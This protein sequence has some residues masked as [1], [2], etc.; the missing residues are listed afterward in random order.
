MTLKLGF[1]VNPIAGLGGKKAWKGTDYI[2]E[3]WIFFE[4]GEHYSFGRVKTA[5]ESIPDS[6]PLLI[7]YCGDPM[8]EEIINLFPFE[9]TLIYQPAGERTSAEDTKDAC[10]AFLDAKVDLILFVGGDGTARDVASIIKDQ[11]PVL[12]IPSGVK[13]HSGCF[14][15]RPE[16]LGDILE[17]MYFGD[18]TFA[19]ENVMDINEDLFRENRVESRLFGYL[20]VP[21]KIGL[22]QGGKVSSAFTSIETYESMAEELKDEYDV[23]NGIVILGTGGTV[24]HVIKSL[25]IEKTLLGIDILEN[26]KIINKDVNEETLYNVVKDRD[27]RMILTPIGGQGF[28][29]G[30]GNQQIS[31]RVINS[32]RSLKLL[33]ISTEEKLHTIDQL[34]LDLNDLVEIQDIKNGYVRVLVEYHQYKLTKINVKNLH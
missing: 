1:I 31:A 33:I 15:Y 10:K 16:D 14:L 23:Y 26:G 8:G 28:V 22:I 4:K 13:M 25:G 2:D 32:V 5:M 18:I 30:R 24:F 19:P 29:L 12:G 7:H 6:I 20:I 21:Q 17:E 9:K 34:Q 11:I 27:V 3:A